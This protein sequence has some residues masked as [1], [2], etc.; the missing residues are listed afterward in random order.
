MGSFCSLLGGNVDTAAG[1]TVY[2]LPDRA[3][4][5]FFHIFRR[6]RGRNDT[7]ARLRVIYGAFPTL[8]RLVWKCGRR[9][10]NISWVDGRSSNP[11]SCDVLRRSVRTVAFNILFNFQVQHI[12]FPKSTEGK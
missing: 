9:I 1:R 3:L 5:T 11:R 4:L 6:R 8:N 2:L 12:Q 7:A 10:K